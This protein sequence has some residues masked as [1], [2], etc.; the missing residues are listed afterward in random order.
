LLAFQPYCG[1]HFRI[2]NELVPPE[3]EIFLIRGLF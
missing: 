3:F 1:R 2:A